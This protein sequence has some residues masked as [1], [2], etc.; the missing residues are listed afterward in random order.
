MFIIN[1][2]T[3]VIYNDDTGEIAMEIE[4]VRQT[5]TE[6]E[7]EQIFLFERGIPGFEEHT[8]F[9]L[10]PLTDT[11]FSYLQSLQESEVALLVTDPFLFFPNYEFDLPEGVVEELDLGSSIV[12]R[13]IVTLKKDVKQSTINLLGPVIFNLDNRLAK[14]VILHSTD[15]H[16][17]HLL[18]P[19][20][21]SLLSPHKEGE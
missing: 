3:A 10:L 15:Y 17:R 16:P 12:I 1:N 4:Q 20:E 11:P 14:Q 7:K 8:R 13:C 9:S 2:W 19:A 5:A 6:F 21:S 18:F